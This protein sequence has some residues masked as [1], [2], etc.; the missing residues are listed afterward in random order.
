MA[1]MEKLLIRGG[2]PLNGPVSVAGSKN[3]TLPIMAACLL[4]DEPVLL[5]GVPRVADVATL[6]HVLNGLGLQTVLLPT[7]ALHLHSSDTSQSE[8]DPDLVRRMRASFCVLGPLLARRGYA[9]VSLPGGCRIDDRPVDLHLKGL[10]ALGAE[11][12]I[13]GGQVTARAT[14]LHG[15]V[16][17]LL[18]RRGPSVTGTCN[19]MSA[20]VL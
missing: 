5:E 14:R 9:K 13:D 3:A 18:G 12:S 16:I 7:G 19:V 20:A 4:T 1:D 10:E 17:N 6:S 2:Q 11:I 8:A 15:T